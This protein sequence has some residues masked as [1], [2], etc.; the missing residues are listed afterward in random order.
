MSMGIGQPRRMASSSDLSSTYGTT[1]IFPTIGNCYP[2]QVQYLNQ[3][4]LYNCSRCVKGHVSNS[5]LITTGSDWNGGNSSFFNQNGITA[6]MKFS[7]Y[8]QNIRSDYLTPF[9]SNKYPESS[10][11]IP[12]Y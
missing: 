2:E 10:Q 4:S 3:N 1:N 5:N 11:A 12:N 8:A 6:S 7:G 9:I